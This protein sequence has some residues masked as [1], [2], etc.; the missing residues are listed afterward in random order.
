M[1]NL[2][3]CNLP[4]MHKFPNS[5]DL[6]F[7]REVPRRGEGF[8]LSCLFKKP[9]RFARPL[10]KGT[11]E[12]SEVIYLYSNLV[13]IQIKHSFINKK[14]QKSSSTVQILELR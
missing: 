6:P 11:P 14:L 2:K 12:Q 4:L 10:K 5:V 8:V 3:I 7:L 9:L 1:S 13:F